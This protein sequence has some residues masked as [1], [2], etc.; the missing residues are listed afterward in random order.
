MT[1]IAGQL[2]MT[3]VHV[4]LLCLTGILLVSL[5]S[6]VQRSLSLERSIAHSAQQTSASSNQATAHWP[7]PLREHAAEL[8][9]CGLS[10]LVALQGSSPIL[11]A[12]IETIASAFPFEHLA[13]LRE[14][15]LLRTG[16]LPK[17]LQSPC[18]LV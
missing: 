18:V 1:R 5:A 13:T 14:P 2:S 8:G 15:P 12:S 17:C 10:S 11:I 3:L 7:C 6:N 4:A 16:D 9:A